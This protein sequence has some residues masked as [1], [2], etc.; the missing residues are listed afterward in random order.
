MAAAEEEDDGE[1]PR[2]TSHP[3]S[4]VEPS[5]DEPR[6]RG[7][8]PSVRVDER[9]RGAGF[10]VPSRGEHRPARPSNLRRHRRPAPRGGFRAPPDPS[11]AAKSAGRRGA[12]GRRLRGPADARDVLRNARVVLDIADKMIVDSRAGSSFP[13]AAGGGLR[14]RRQDPSPPR[15]SLRENTELSAAGARLP[16]RV[17]RRRHRR[18]RRLRRQRPTRRRRLRFGQSSPSRLAQT[19]RGA[20]ILPLATR[21]RHRRSRLRIRLRLRLSGPGEF[22][23]LVGCLRRRRPRR[24]PST[25]ASRFEPSDPS[26]V[27]VETTLAAAERHDLVDPRGWIAVRSRISSARSNANTAARI[28]TRPST[29]RTSSRRSL[30]SCRRV[31]AIRSTRTR[32]S[33]WWWRRRRTT[34]GILDSTTRT[35]FGRR[36][37]RRRDGTT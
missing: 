14:P 32:R 12:R 11:G 35:W 10:R 2:A 25:R 5:L 18:R 26:G 30:S 33:R 3:R 9:G 28:I 37:R 1:S 8:P 29:P 22:H 34:R 19:S 16:P 21:R 13:A 20:R 36:T 24:T 17:R 15:V 6:V 27:L 4:G 23:R 31:F 7:R